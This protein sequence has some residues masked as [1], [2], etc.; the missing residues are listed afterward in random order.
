MVSNIQT[1]DILAAFFSVYIDLTPHIRYGFGWE[2]QLAELTFHAMFMAPLIS[3]NPI[4][5][6]SA[7][8]IVTVYVSLQYFFRMSLSKI[9]NLYPC[10]SGNALVPFS[11]ND[12][13]WINQTTE[14]RSK[15]E[16]E[17][18]YYNGLL[19]RNTT[20]SKSINEILSHGTEMVAQI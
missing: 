13:S 8:P 3:L 6:T 20:S 12:W 1:F 9:S 7:V 15:M 2:P 18:S 14:W 4:P 11:H 10:T 19:L 5:R 16:N 17:K